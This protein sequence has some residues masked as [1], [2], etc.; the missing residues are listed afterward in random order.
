PIWLLSK[1]RKEE[2]KNALLQIRGLHEETKFSGE[3]VFIAYTVDIITRINIT[4]DS[5]LITVVIGIIQV[6]VNIITTSCSKK[7]GR[8]LISIVSGA[9]MSISL[10]ALALYLQFFEETGVAVVPL[11]CILLYVAFA[12]FGFFSIPWSMIPELYPTRYINV[13]A[14]LTVILAFLCD[15]ISTQLYPLMIRTDR[16]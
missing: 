15:Y 16:N 9:G 6:I 7:I 10:G 14:M 11:V 12:S 1:G 4:I 5:F 8:R 3:F 2:A 13:L